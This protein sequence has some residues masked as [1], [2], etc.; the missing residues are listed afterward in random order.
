MAI[1]R[2]PGNHTWKSSRQN[3]IIDTRS[4]LRTLPRNSTRVWVTSSS[5]VSGPSAY[6]VHD[7]PQIGSM[8][9]PSP[10]LL[11]PLP[12]SQPFQPMRPCGRLRSHKSFADIT[13]FDGILTLQKPREKIERNWLSSS[14]RTNRPSRRK[15]LV[16]KNQP[17]CNSQTVKK[18]F[19][20]FRAE[21]GF[22]LSLALTQFFAE[23]MIS[24]FA[25][26]VTAL[27]KVHK[28]TSS[29]GTFW[30]ASL[31]SLVL[32]A[33]LLLWARLSDMYDSYYVFMAG[34]L[35]LAIWGLIPVFCSS[36]IWIDISRAMQGLAI[37]AY[38]PATFSLIASIYVEG[39]RKN[40]VLGIYSGC[41]PL[42][43]FAGILI[44]GA[45][46]PQKAEW[47]WL[48][49]T[50]LSTVVLITTFFCVPGQ[51]TFRRISQLTMDWKGAFLIV[52][53]LLLVS[54]ALA[55]EPFAS[56]N[57]DDQS[58]FTCPI[59]LAP[60]SIG[61]VGL[62]ITIWYEWW[63]ATCP[64]IPFNFFKPRS[65][66]AVLFAC[67]F[68]YASDSIWLYNSAE[69]FQIPG[70]ARPI[71]APP[72]SLVEVAL[73]YTPAAIG[74]I[75]LCIA[76]GLILHMIPI[77]PLLLFSGI[78]WILAPLLLSLAPLPFDYWKYVVPSMLCATI[79]IDLTFT[80]SVIFLSAIQ[81]SHYQGLAGAISSILI[82]LA[83]PFA[84]SISR[85]IL[86]ETTEK[87][88]SSE[89]ETIA[90]YRATLIYASAS[91]GIGFII[92]VFFVRISRSIVRNPDPEKDV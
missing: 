32:S 47:Y 68:F 34:I 28:E 84:L 3:E 27:L 35:W 6:A 85:I 75:V 15:Y 31:L 81:P 77:L 19:R 11:S 21:V 38:L 78:A 49:V 64:L 87:N 42:G 36:L 58:G 22:C 30:P 83:M 70:V 26:E 43:F 69:M 82:N 1:P 53:S 4:R 44:A 54:Y 66:T 29:M 33:T 73:W 25:I 17:I 74:G 10:A 72:L 37:A 90:G 56:R 86:E 14:S 88:E 52:T 55:V 39:P 71:D 60:L 46:P 76:G 20:N 79:G 50:C 13:S 2:G 7:Q 41:A 23:Y 92:C 24:G 91:A 5:R 51:R 57:E 89:A 18:N 80:I 67:I 8:R 59:V 9:V 45:L 12:I 40:L 65:V 62:A 63:Y 61:V 16:L 48:V